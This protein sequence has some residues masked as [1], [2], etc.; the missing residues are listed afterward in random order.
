M[1][2]YVFSI[3]YLLIFGFSG[4]FASAQNVICPDKPSDAKVV[5]GT[6]MG[7]F[8]EDSEN[9]ARVCI[10]NGEGMHCFMAEQQL[11]AKLFGYR[12]GMP[13]L[14]QYVIQQVKVDGECYQNMVLTDGKVVNNDPR[15]A[16]MKQRESITF[17][18]CSG[19]GQSYMTKC[20]KDKQVE[21][22]PI[23]PV[24]FHKDGTGIM[25]GYRDDD[26]PLTWDISGNIVMITSN[27][28]TSVYRLNDERFLVNLKN[29]NDV[30][31]SVGE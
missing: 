25:R 21:I 3:L 16:L 1:M 28:G 8:D 29:D 9:H 7:W 30:M 6:Y 11:A 17:H 18:T 27:G 22:S 26:T 15:Q 14:A 4:D 19:D 23:N 2:K 5:Q 24:I 10:A 13:V 12:D 20:L 31:M